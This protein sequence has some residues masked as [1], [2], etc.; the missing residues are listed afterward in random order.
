MWSHLVKVVASVH[1]AALRVPSVVQCFMALPLAA[2]VLGDTLKLRGSP[3]VTLRRLVR[4]IAF[5][6][7][8]DTPCM[9]TVSVQGAICSQASNRQGGCT[10]VALRVPY[11]CIRH[12]DIPP[13]WHFGC[14][15]VGNLEVPLAQACTAT[16]TSKSEEHTG[17]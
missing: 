8:R 10:A 4:A 15:Q 3:E 2:M 17:M 14:P 9:Q 6:Q 16:R 11:C 12:R 7:W 5:W 13:V 1:R